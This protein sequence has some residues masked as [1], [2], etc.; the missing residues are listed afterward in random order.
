MVELPEPERT[1]DL[2][3]E[4]AIEDRRS[5]RDY[6][7]RPL[8]LDDLGQI[9]WAAQGITEPRRDLRAAP[10]AGALYPLEVYVAAGEV[11]ELTSGV[12]RYRP[13][14]HELVRA[15]DG[16]HRGEL[17]RAALNQSWI[18][19]APAVVVIAAVYERT[20]R[21]YGGRADRY[22]HMEVGA[23]AENVY[24]QAEALGLAT[25][26]VGAFRDGRV[27]DVL[28]LPDDHAPLGLMPLGH[29]P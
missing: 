20:E 14:G 29:R 15:T 5:R 26:L 24:L 16:D 13:A 4:A 11:S 25:V 3:T 19:S 28:A 27:R 2:S 23:A 6:G 17:A 12:Y 22:V 10:S 9:L 1:G 8:S 18:R 7:D 21:R